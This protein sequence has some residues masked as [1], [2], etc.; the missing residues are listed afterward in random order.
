MRSV[1]VSLVAAVAL[2][3]CRSAPKTV[4]QPAVQTASADTGFHP[5][6]SRKAV[7]YE[8]NVR[9]YTPEG[10]FAAFQQHLPRLKKLGVDILWIMP[11]QP[12]GKK[13]RK[14]TGPQTALTTDGGGRVYAFTRTRDTNTVLVAVNFGDSAA[15][16][17]YEGM[18]HPGEYIDWFGKSKVAMTAAG[19]LDIPAHGY[20][21]LVQ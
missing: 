21:V 10:T 6:W 11:V 19:S 16:V 15:T 20:R 4:S 1:L 9:Q 2:S 18:R 8:V 17:K 14:G 7:I 12:I 13:N 5:A 3:A